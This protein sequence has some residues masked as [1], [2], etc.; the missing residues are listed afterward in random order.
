MRCRE[1][2]Y[3]EIRQ[4]N[5][6]A[7]LLLPNIWINFINKEK[8]WKFKRRYKQDKNNYTKINSTN[9]NIYLKRTYG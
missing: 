8:I 6:F 7:V 1:R 3:Y 9:T 4:N 5:E 2:P